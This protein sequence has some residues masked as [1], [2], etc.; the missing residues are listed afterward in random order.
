[1]KK[2]D[3]IRVSVMVMDDNLPD[4][5]I[6]SDHA[7]LEQLPGRQQQPSPPSSGRALQGQL[8]SRTCAP[9][10]GWPRYSVRVLELALGPRVYEAAPK[11]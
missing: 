4:W 9:E 6:R 7:D 8:M 11:M 10:A 1:M 2:P 5:E 3:T